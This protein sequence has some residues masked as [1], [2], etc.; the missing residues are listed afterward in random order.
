MTTPTDAVVGFFLAV[1]RRDWSALRAAMTDPIRSDYTSLGGG[2][3]EE[4]PAD[5]LVGRWRALLPGFDVTQ[6]HLGPLGVV[7]ADDAR[8][9][10]A[11]SVRGYHRIGD[12]EW[13]VAGSYDLVLV[14]DAGAWR[15]AG[16]TLHVSHVTGDT[17]LAAEATA[18]AASAGQ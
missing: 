6:H 16:I 13:M 15:I 8:T 1:D 2:E 14:R 18:R 7:S 5:E 10:L 9:A 12:R 11:C 3:P 4:L 17:D